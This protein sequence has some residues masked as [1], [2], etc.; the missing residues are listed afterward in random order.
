MKLDFKPFFIP[1]SKEISVLL[2]TRGRTTSLQKSV[3]SL[4]ELADDP[5]KL[6]LCIGFDNDDTDTIAWFHENVVPDIQK[7][8]TDIKVLEFERLGYLRLNEYINHLAKISVGKWFMFWNDDAW[9]K[10]QGWDTEITNRTEK[11]RVLR[12]PTHNEHPYA[13]FPIVPREWF[14]LFG[15]LS[16]HQLN[17][18]WISQ[19]GYILNIVENIA[20]EC[21][22]DRADLTGNNKD[23]TFEQGAIHQMLEGNPSDPRDFNHVSWSMHRYRDADKLAWYLNTKG[24]DVTW[25]VNV[26]TGQQDPWEYMLSKEQDPNNQVSQLK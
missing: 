21:V 20:V 25:Y 24:E 13:I 10:T 4:I 9:M 5:T 22:H 1:T 23:E 19:V 7:A 6:E 2:P 17:D 11:F 26:M 8:G 16:P 15:Y 3:M 12:I 14:T 18:A